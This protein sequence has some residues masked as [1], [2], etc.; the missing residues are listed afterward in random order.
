[1][2]ILVTGATGTVGRHVVARLLDAGEKVRALT[3]R[4]DEA[5]LPEKAEVVQGDLALPET[6]EKAF[7]GVEK[8]YLF[9]VGQTAKEVVDLAARSGVRRVVVLS[10]DAVVTQLETNQDSVSEHG[11]VE[12]AVEAADVEWTFLRP[13]AFAG[14]ALFWAH[15]ISTES[16]VRTAYPDAAQALVHEAD[17][18]DVAVAALLE[19]GHAGAKYRLTGPESITQLAQVRTIGEVLG[20]EIRFEELTHEQKREEMLQF[21]PEDSVDMIL[22]YFVVAVDNPDVVLPTVQEVTGRPA[23]TFA[24]WV[25]DHT[26][27]FQ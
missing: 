3:R 23:R 10:S 20:R 6:L 13:F 24:D 19:D 2:T 11:T 1:M 17:I 7:H 5:G 26:A 25:A 22:G 27:D 18:A 15:S 8:L 12:R 4:P 16:V 14:N 21:I 9:P